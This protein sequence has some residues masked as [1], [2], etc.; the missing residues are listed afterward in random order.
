[1]MI[2]EGKLYREYS[3]FR[4]IT[5]KLSEFHIAI[6]LL[7]RLRV[8]KF[9]E[10]NELI[11]RFMLINISSGIAMG[12][13]NFIFPVYA[14]SLNATS[15]EIGLIKG[16]SGIGD[17]LVVLPAGFMVDYF[18]SRQ[19]Y[20]ASGIFGAA[21]IMLFSLIT[22]PTMLLVAMFFFG[23]A[24]S[25]RVI[26]L[27]AAFLKNMDT[28]GV[29]KAGWYKGS[30]TIGGGFIGPIMGGIASI[31]MAFTGYF[32][33]TSAF[34]LAPLMVI[35]THAS[36]RDDSQI[37]PKNSSFTDASNHYKSLAKNR[38]L[39]R[40][41]VIESL[42]TS[43]FITFTTFITVLVI[44]ELGLSPG[45]AAMLISLKGG[46]TIFVV[47]F[48]GQLL[49]KNNNN[50][51]LFS[52]TIII[53]ALL[54][55]GMSRSTPLLAIASMVLGIGSGLTTLITFTEIG[56]IDGEKG[57]ISGIFSF[58][59][60][61]GAILGPALGGIVGGIF[62]IRAIFLGFVPLFAALSL[63]TFMDSRKPD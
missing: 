3:F 59:H 50:L 34:L 20:F 51:Y 26:S 18:G 62:G 40:A 42:N 55:L 27:N 63:F 61:T 7:F 46:V 1:M 58:G 6:Y 10:G 52:F 35:Y 30:M 47:F 23:V 24:R 49:R 14:L 25:F 29:R 12:M 21:I 11:F 8:M 28:I 57:K 37:K 38:I 45:I 54:M 2:L 36:R 43:F 33:F 22:T 16:I 5:T 17:L 39:V 15:A 19:M 60:S 13:I 53:L 56:T 48:C 9:F 31:A 4:A 41:T 32:A 44:R